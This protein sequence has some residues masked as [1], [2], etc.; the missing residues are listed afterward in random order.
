[1]ARTGRV[2]H[3]HKYF[4]HEN[5][6]W[7]C[8]GKDGCSHYIPKN[9]PQPV[10]RMS[11]CWSCDKP[12]M[13]TPVNMNIDKPK[14]DECV[15]RDDILDDFIERKL[16]TVQKPNPLTEISRQAREAVE[17]AKRD[18]LIKDKIEVISED[19]GSH[20]PDCDVWNS[21]ECNCKS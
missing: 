3:T 12:F 11:D 8:S 20:A 4:R 13:L 1:M 19:E 15:E 10:G 9:M 2:N 7:Y 18:Q 14:C 16:A 5:G 17:K 6:L 21:G